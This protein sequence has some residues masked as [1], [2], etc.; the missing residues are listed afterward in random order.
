M[1]L[2]KMK[3]RL[4]DIVAKLGEYKALA[5]LGEDEVASINALNTEFGDLKGQIQAR[6]AIEAM[7]K[8]SSISNRKVAALPK[9]E[10][11]NEKKNDNKKHG[12][13]N[14]GEFYRAVALHSNGKTDRRLEMYNAATEKVGEDGGFL[15]PEDFRD[16]VNNK[17]E[18]P[19]SLLAKTTQF[20]TAS[21]QLSF[22]VNESAVW[23]GTGIQAFWTPELGQYQKSQPIFAEKNFRLHKVTALVPV[24][25]ELLQDAAAIESYIKAQA[26]QAIVHKVN[27]AIISGDGVGKPMGFLNS[28]FK[29]KVAKESGQAADSIIF[30]N[31]NNMEARLLPLSKPKAVWLV[32]PQVIPALR[33]MK[34]DVGGG[35]NVPAYLPS[36]GLSGAPY[37]TL[38]GLPIM[39]LMSGVK[40]LGDEGDISLVDLSYYWSLVKTDGVQSSMSNHVYFDRD[41]NLYKFSFRVGG[42][43]PYSTPVTTEFGNFSMSGIVTLEAR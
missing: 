30:E 8:D 25:E 42:M 38:M 12:F 17:V 20:K 28:G 34:F 43:V 16:A 40:A 35:Q 4:A 24:S 10:T 18:G 9:I 21:N 2:E 14:A 37:G 33:L 6:E 31:I 3:A 23:D 1:E 15:L 22:P 32:N 11:A 7:T 39:P 26:P 41:Q 36:T 29:Y 19:E 13:D 5:T 27:T